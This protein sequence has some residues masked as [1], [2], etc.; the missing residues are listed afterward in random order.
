[1]EKFKELK[2]LVESMEDDATK[3]YEKGNRAAGT[4]IRKGMQELKKMAQDIR[5][6]VQG[7]KKT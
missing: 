5:V 3:F 1:M 6:E 4:R 2:A 7:M